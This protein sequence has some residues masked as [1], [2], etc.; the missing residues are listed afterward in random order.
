MMCNHVPTLSMTALLPD[1]DDRLRAI[2]LSPSN[3]TVPLSFC[4]RLLVSLA[5]ANNSSP[6][7]RQQWL[8]GGISMVQ[9]RRVNRLR[10]ALNIEALEDRMLLSGVV[11]AG[12]DPATGLLSIT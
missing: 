11:Y 9:K 6:S 3:N 4:Q 8:C 1:A 2:E 12:E 7:P 5:V 10:R